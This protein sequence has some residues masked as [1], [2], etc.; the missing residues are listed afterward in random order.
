VAVLAACSSGGGSHTAA[1]EPNNA[2]GLVSAVRAMN[3]PLLMDGGPSLNASD[4]SE[5]CRREFG[6]QLDAALKQETEHARGPS[7]DNV[8]IT[9]SVRNVQHGTGEANLQWKG[10]AQG[11]KGDHGSQGWAVYRYETGRWR[12]DPC[13]PPGGVGYAAP[14]ALARP[15]CSTVEGS[16]ASLVVFAKVGLSQGRLTELGMRLAREESVD[17]VRLVHVT[18]GEVARCLKLPASMTPTPS[19]LPA[20]FDVWLS[21]GTNPEQVA[22]AV[23]ALPDVNR[24]VPR[25]Q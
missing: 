2:A 4:V 7:L 10:S 16:G 20:Q 5:A 24:V 19:L 17:R 8:T 13:S 14:S 25:P 9:V 15:D 11:V 21:R 22:S 18:P 23:V 1:Q 12:I 6:S 3:R